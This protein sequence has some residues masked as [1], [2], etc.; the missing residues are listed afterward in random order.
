[1]KNNTKPNV[2]ETIKTGQNSE[3][4]KNTQLDAE[5]DYSADEDFRNDRE[6][7]L[8][9]MASDRRRFNVNPGWFIFT[10]AL[11]SL[12]IVVLSWGSVETKLLS[13]SPQLHG[14][15]VVGSSIRFVIVNNTSKTKIFSKVKTTM[16]FDGEY[17]GTSTGRIESG[18]AFH[19]ELGPGDNVFTDEFEYSLR[20]GEETAIEFSMVHLYH[21]YI[22]GFW[23]IEPT[24]VLADGSTISMPV[25]SVEREYGHRP[26]NLDKLRKHWNEAFEKYGP[27]NLPDDFEFL[28]PVYDESKPSELTA[29]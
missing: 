19:Y 14:E 24:L 23:E 10:L 8:S 13:Q 1:M 27:G 4:S 16:K 7:S 29:E 25:A 11:I 21:E 2:V 6:P 9:P 28:L 12:A 3:T 26:K 22:K 18:A 15:Q 5:F 17:W 20:P